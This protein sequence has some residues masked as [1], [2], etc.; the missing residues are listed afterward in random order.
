MLVSRSINVSGRATSPILPMVSGANCRSGRSGG[1]GRTVRSSMM[2]LVGKCGF[3]LIGEQQSMNAAAEQLERC[4]AE[5][6]KTEMPGIELG[7]HLARM[8]RHHQDAVAD[9]ERLVDRVR[10]EEHTSEL[11]S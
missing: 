7:L 6:G 2:R 9:Q 4:R 8:R 1:N 11:Q 5:I 3:D 10:S